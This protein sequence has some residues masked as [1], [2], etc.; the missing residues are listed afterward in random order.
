MNITLAAK[1]NPP[2]LEKSD[3]RADNPPRLESSDLR[4]YS[5]GSPPTDGRDVRLDSA[6][7]MGRSSGNNR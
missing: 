7:Y 2:R 5:L 6:G 4:L 3:L 1:P